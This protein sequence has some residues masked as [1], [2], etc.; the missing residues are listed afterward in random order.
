M[1]EETN[2]PVEESPKS[3]LSVLWDK[4]SDNIWTILLVIGFIWAGASYFSPKEPAPVNKFADTP[5]AQATQ[6]TDSSD[7]EEK[8]C[9]IKGNISASGEKIFHSPGDRFYNVTRIDTSAGERW[10]CSKEEAEEAG[11]RESKV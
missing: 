3:T 5:S 10:F 2:Q 7:E 1:S 6:N 8:N 4:F 9:D 11:W